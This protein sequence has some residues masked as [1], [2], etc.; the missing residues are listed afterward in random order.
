[1]S[2]LSWTVGPPTG[3]R[4]LLAC[5]YGGNHFPHI[6]T[7]PQNRL[8]QH[9]NLGGEELQMV[10]I[11]LF[12]RMS[13]NKNFWAE[14]RGCTWLSM[15]L[16]EFPTPVGLSEPSGFPVVATTSVQVDIWGSERDSWV[17]ASGCNLG[18]LVSPTALHPCVTVSLFA[19][20]LKWNSQSC[21]FVPSVGWETP[22]PPV[23]E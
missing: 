21:C 7:E 15:S 8:R 5:W 18:I 20:G 10:F 22:G 2:E 17:G 3:V 11:I 13:E 9:Q 4:E 1:M 16:F 19:S 23:P 6:G 12:K 14:I